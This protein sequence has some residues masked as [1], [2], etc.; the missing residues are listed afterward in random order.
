MLEYNRYLVTSALPY[1]NGPLHIG[2]L[3]GAYLSADVF[4]RFMRMMDKDIVFICGSDENG[5]AITMR[6]LKESKTP[7]EIIDTYHE[8]FV[9]TFEGIGIS[10]DYYGRTSSDLHHKTSQDFFRELLS[11]N[12]FVEQETEQY[13]DLEAQQFLADRY[14]MG[15]CPKCGHPDAYGDQCEKCGSSLNPIELISPRSVITGSVPELRVTRHWFLGLDQ[16]EQW[17]KEWIERGTLEGK[18]HHDPEAWKNHVVGQCKSW[19]DA[20]LSPRSMTRD[21]D[22]GVDVPQEI[23]GSKGKKL[24]VWLDAPIGY[25]SATKQWAADHQKDWKDYWQKEDSALIHFIG[26]D[27]IVFHCIIFPAILKAHGQFNLPVNVPA[28]QFMNLEGQK[29]S[30]SRNWAVWVHEYLADFPN[31]QDSLR[32]YLCKNMPEQKDSEFTWKLFPEAH[33]AELVNNLSNFIHRVFVLTDKYFKGVVPDFDPDYPFEGVA[34]D[35]LGGFHETELLYLFDQIQAMNQCLR[36]YDF[37]GAL[38]YV[39]DISSSGNLLLQKNEPWKNFKNDPEWVEVVMN[40]ALQYVA[41]LSVIVRPF[42]PFTSDKLRTMLGLDRLEEKGE[43][44]KM[45]DELAEGGVIISPHHKLAKFDYLFTKID[46][47]VIDIQIQKL[48]GQDQQRV[49]GLPDTQLQY[50]EQKSEIS[51]DDFIKLDLRTAR[52]ILAEIVPKADKLLQLTLDLGF[53]K[54]TVLS[55]IAEH[56]KP[57]EIIGKEVVVVA[58]LAPRKIRGI[59]SRGMILMAENAEGKLNFIPG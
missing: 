36:E 44:V 26:K 11:K 16:H 23:P 17:L 52:I 25:I 21:L 53:E 10:F 35:E 19:L 29:I 12:Q 47:S 3:S 33:H 8:M 41:C 7:Q 51:I 4:V 9:K 1:A 57:D 28:N 34:G 20:G 15:T 31:M 14:I 40:L 13:Y 27:N 2:H 43:L 45:L 37:R 46:D 39:M 42:L 30:T 24:Y 6:A 5:A 59:E 38:K 58:N 48:A 56:Y 49:S 32:Y 22:W 54:R 18:E 50:A 55:G